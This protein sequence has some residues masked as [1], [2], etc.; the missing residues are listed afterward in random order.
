MPK[1]YAMLFFTALGFNFT[2]THI[3]NW[4]LFL[5]WSTLFILSGTISLP[6][7]NSILDTYQPRELIFQC[8]V[9]LPFHYC[10]RGSWVKNTGVVFH[11]L[12]QWTMFFQYSPPWLVTMTDLSFVAL[13]SMAHSFIE[14]YKAVTH[15]IILVSF[16]WLWFL[17]W[18]LNDC[19]CCFSCLPSEGGE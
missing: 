12:L 8:H 3:H 2:T 9:F 14:L 11:P 16:L 4:A 7:P 5:L 13:H 6:F 15:V 17:F 18:W 19:S 1:S 10:S